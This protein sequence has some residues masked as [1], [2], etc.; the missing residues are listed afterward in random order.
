[1][2]HR[3]VWALDYHDVLHEDTAVA[4]ASFPIIANTVT[5]I[6]GLEQI[7]VFGLHNTVT[8]AVYTVIVVEAEA[9]FSRNLATDGIKGVQ[10]LGRALLVGHLLHQAVIVAGPTKLVT[11]GEGVGHVAISGIS[12]PAN[13]VYQ[14]VALALNIFNLR[15]LLF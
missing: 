15:I 8:E 1:M 12:R 2:V 6:Q 13:N 9:S 14:L 11:V 5:I 7:A 3:F 4:R 10:E